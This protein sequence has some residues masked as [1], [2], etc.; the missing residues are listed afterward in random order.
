MASGSL[1]PPAFPP[2]RWTVSCTG[3]AAASPTPRWRPCCSISRA[4]HTIV[5]M[6]DLWAAPG[7][8]A[9]HHG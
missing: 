1:P 2:W 5:F 4:G 3:T 9:A 6:I 8:A 7:T